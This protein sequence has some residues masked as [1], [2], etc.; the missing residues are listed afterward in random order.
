MAT[1]DSEALCSKEQVK[2][3]LNKGVADTGDD[4]RIIDLINAASKW[5][6]DVHCDRK[7]SRQTH[8]NERHSGDGAKWLFL[9]H[10]PIISITSLYDDTNRPP[11]WGSDTL[12][13]SDDYEI[14]AGING[15]ILFHASYPST[16]TANVKATYLAGYNRGAGPGEDDDA[17]PADLQRAAMM[18]VG[19]MFRNMKGGR[20]G[21]K[22]RSVE[23]GG[24]A[25]FFY[26]KLLTPY[27]KTVLDFY[28]RTSA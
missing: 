13:D 16:G 9:N 7:F 22:Q 17:L 28:K 10:Y 19:Q 3:I 21:L 14:L 23:G 4:D 26:E 1:L 25:V 20:G 18:L 11:E 15:A 6:E 24:S 5:I 2:D 27:V 12:I 8:S